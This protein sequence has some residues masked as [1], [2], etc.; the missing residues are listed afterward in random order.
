VLDLV[1]VELFF[2]G[3]GQRTELSEG[4]GQEVED[5]EDAG[6]ALSE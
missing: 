5:N 4:T 1:A 3:G 2:E 6:A